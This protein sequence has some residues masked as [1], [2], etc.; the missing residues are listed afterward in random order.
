[1][2]YW[3]LGY[4][5]KGLNLAAEAVALSEHLAFPLNSELALLYNAMLHLERGEPELALRR[6]GTAE[7][8]AMEQRLAFVVEPQF[9]R[10]AALTE[11]GAYAD[12]VVCLRE[13]LAGRLGTMRDRPYGLA[14]LAE[15]LALQGDNVA[16]LAMAAEGLETAERTGNRQWEPELQRLSGVALWGLDRL[17]EAE[18]GLKEALRVAQH[19]CAKSYELRAATNLDR[20]WGSGACVPKPLNCSHQFALVHGGIRHR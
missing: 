5:Q 6:I 1:M 18:R 3:V 14:R 8:L 13:G 2:V 11:L 17:E 4:P 9:L 15:A 7:A 20:L 16:A 12:A 10:G 19:Q